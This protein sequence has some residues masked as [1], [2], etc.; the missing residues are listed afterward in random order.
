MGMAEADALTRTLLPH[1]PPA[2]APITIN[3][4]LPDATASG[5]A[6]G[7]LWERSSSQANTPRPYHRK[8]AA[9][10]RV[11]V[12]CCPNNTAQPVGIVGLVLLIMSASSPGAC[13]AGPSISSVTS[14]PTV[15]CI[16]YHS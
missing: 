11:V 4:S 6:P 13:L 12:A 7:G 1:Y 9:L 2:I 3:G 15:K 8:S 16:F 5:R 14:P 10:L